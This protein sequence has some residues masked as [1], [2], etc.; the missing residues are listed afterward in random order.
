MVLTLNEVLTKVKGLI[1]LTVEA[2]ESPLQTRLN[3]K[4]VVFE[5]TSL[6]DAIMGRPLLFNLRATMSIYHY[7][8][9]FS[10][11][12]G[13]GKVKGNK[14]AVEECQTK[15]NLNRLNSRIPPSVY[16]VY[17]SESNL[18]PLDPCPRIKGGKLVEEPDK[19][20]ISENDPVK[21]L[22]IGHAL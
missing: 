12:H 20:S 11:P 19:V 4:F 1:R 21:E 15:I 9:K 6:Y 5:S 14:E 2:G 7:L 3:A 17:Q 13:I 10:T 22:K 16:M 8:I 18:G